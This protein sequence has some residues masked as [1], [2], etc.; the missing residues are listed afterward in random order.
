MPTALKDLIPNASPEAIQLMRDMMMW[1]PKKRPT[2]AQALRYPYFQVGQNLP[3]PSQP[4]QPLQQ[5]QPPQ[6]QPQP[7]A[8]QQRQ[9]QQV[10]RKDSFNFGSGNEN[11]RVAVNVQGH[12][13]GY[14]SARKRWG[15]GTGVKDSVDEFESLLS[16]IDTSHG[17]ATK[18]VGK[19]Y[20]ISVL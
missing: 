1:D 8:Q 11:K 15:E 3:K 6:P 7:Q 2:C 16:E 20:Y 12:A 10:E 9:A 19:K 14:G 17:S 18:K 13:S 4:T 5:R